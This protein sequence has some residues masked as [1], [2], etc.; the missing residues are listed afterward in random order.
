MHSSF[1]MLSNVK[2]S[3]SVGKVVGE[4]SSS[5]GGLGFFFLPMMGILK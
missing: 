5:M 3:A 1:T 2:S 4:G